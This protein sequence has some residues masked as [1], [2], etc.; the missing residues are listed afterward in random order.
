MWLIDKLFGNDNIVKAG[1]AGL[2]PWRGL[3][4]L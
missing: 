2:M 4:P 1:I 3:L